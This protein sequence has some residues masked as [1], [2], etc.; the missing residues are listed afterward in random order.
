[1]VTGGGVLVPLHH[2]DLD[3]SIVWSIELKLKIVVEG[4]YECIDP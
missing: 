4:I 1:M 3:T 2:G